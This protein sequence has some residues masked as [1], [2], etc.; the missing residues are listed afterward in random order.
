MPADPL[1]ISLQLVKTI[2]D[3]RS[4]SSVSDALHS[5]AWMHQI[6]GFVDPCKTGIVKRVHQGA[7]RHLACPRQRKTPLSKKVLKKLGKLLTTGKLADLQTLTLITLG[8]A[9]CLRWDDLSHI[10]VDG[11]SLHQDY[12]AE[13]LQSRKNDQ[14]REGSWVFV[15]RWK[16]ALYP[17]ALTEQLLDQ[18]PQAQLAPLFGRIRSLGGKQVIR[19]TILYSRARESV[20]TALASVGEDPDKYGQH[21]LR[22]GG[23]SVV[24]AAGVPD[25]LTQHHGGCKSEAGMKCYFAESLPNL[26]MVS[27][28]IGL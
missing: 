19:D 1:H 8:F 10:C 18:G 4:P 15:S 9:G 13:F 21:S 12:M 23:V 6:S 20:R 28:T 2:N 7:L 3:S 14:L 27:Q 11:L 24:A 5:V 25:Q 22:S 17:V 26:L 16:G